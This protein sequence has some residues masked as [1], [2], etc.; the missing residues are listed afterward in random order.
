MGSKEEGIGIEEKVAL[1][2]ASLPADC[3]VPAKGWPAN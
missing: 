2:L 3:F 1:V